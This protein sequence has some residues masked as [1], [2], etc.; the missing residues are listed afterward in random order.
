MPMNVPYPLKLRIEDFEL[1][2]RAGVFADL[3]K[4]EL[5]EGTVVAMNAEY[6]PHTVVKNEL[7]FRLRLALTAAGSPYSA[8]VEPTLAL[9]PHNLP[10]PDVVVACRPA[11]RDYF[12]L[13]HCALVI[14]VADSTVAGDLG[15]KQTMY[16]ANG[17]PEYWVFDVVGG[18]VHQF[19]S[20]ADGIYRERRAVRIGAP[21]TSATV[22]DLTIDS[23]GIL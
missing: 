17:I 6:S 15:P 14:E 9:P 12:R 10:Q 13:N 18:K 4:V 7:M 23:A 20:P 21:L 16:A 1:L 19:W 2:E 22:A 5:I 11:E 8:F 3:K